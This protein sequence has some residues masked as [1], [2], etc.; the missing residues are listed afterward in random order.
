MLREC[1]KIFANVAVGIR[2]VVNNRL[3]SRKRS[4]TVQIDSFQFMTYVLH[5]GLQATARVVDVVVRT[6][7]HNTLEIN[8]II[9]VIQ[10]DRKEMRRAS[11]LTVVSSKELP[12]PGD[13]IS[14]KYLPH[15]LSYIVVL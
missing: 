13:I 6:S 11:S 15:D 1:F 8:L 5:A 10:S 12:R 9:D 3:T 7:I 4:G 2:D 14:I